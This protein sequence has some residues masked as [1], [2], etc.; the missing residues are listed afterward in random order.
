[1]GKA[2]SFMIIPS[3]MLKSRHFFH[4]HLFTFHSLDHLLFPVVKLNGAS[5]PISIEYEMVHALSQAVFR[6]K[7]SENLVILDF[8][9][10]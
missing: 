2:N 4:S 8:S 9:S 6:T 1:M 10:F 7:N 3:K 5:Q